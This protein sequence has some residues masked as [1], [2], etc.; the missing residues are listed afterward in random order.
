MS[1]GKKYDIITAWGV[2]EHLQQPSKYF[3]MVYQLLSRGGHFLFL[4]TNIQSIA[5]RYL[6][7]EDIPRHTT[8]FSPYTIE[9]YAS[10]YKYKVVKIYHK[11]DVYALSYKNFLDFAS[12]LIRRKEYTQY[13][14]LNYRIKQNKRISRSFLLASKMLG[15]LALGHDKVR[16]KNAIITALLRK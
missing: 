2:L 9:K 12:H 13:D 3:E 6:Y 14:T 4:V 1:A 10:K 11:N 15:K 5:S 16:R 7:A 8:F